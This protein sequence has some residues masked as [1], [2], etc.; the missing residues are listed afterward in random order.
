MYSDDTVISVKNL[1]KCFEIYQNPSNR[2]WQALWIGKKQF[3]KEF[4]ALK[5]INF[6][7]QKGECIGVIGRN[8]A[9]KSTLLQI[10]TG[11]LPQTTGEVY[12]KG[13][14]AAL[15]ELGSGFNPEFTGR[16]NV[17]MNAAILGFKRSEI[18]E[19]Y[20]EIIK[21]AE[22]GD[23]IDQPVKTY[24]S[25]MMVRLAF[26]VQVVVEPD[27]LIVDEALAV[28]D[29]AF[30]FKCLT[31]IKEIVA[32]GTSVLLVSHDSGTVK[33]FCDKCLWLKKGE[34]YAY[35]N[36]GEIVEAY[37]REVRMETEQGQMSLSSQHVEKK[38]EKSVSEPLVKEAESITLLTDGS[39]IGWAEDETLDSRVAGCR[40]GVGGAKVKKID[41]LDEQNNPL[42]IVDFNQKVKIR[43][44]FELEKEL[45]KLSVSYKI[46][47]AKHIPLLGYGSYMQNDG[48]FYSLQPGRYVIDFM[49]TFP[50]TAG[51]YS[52]TTILSEIT[53]HDRAAISFDY[54][55][56]GFLFSV[57]PRYP[58]RIWTFAQVENQVDLKVCKESK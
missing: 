48:K 36:A 28:G 54:L 24:S 31:R 21:F 39:E 44:F 42:T 47:D 40:Y 37:D 43:V 32:K 14:I 55:E 33:S 3:Y 19:K 4:W 18:E 50:L 2:L 57:N 25:G 9:G 22:I 26:A 35:G 1:S 17:Y 53:I 56:N 49:T 8:G 58:D 29:A 10:I 51:V 13:R 30:Q 16:E 11:T 27:L 34:V 20:Q 7:L 45:N 41:L 46:N 15:L 23:F 12:T 52:I 6:E 38:N 5:N